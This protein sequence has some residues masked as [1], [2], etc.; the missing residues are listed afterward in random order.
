MVTGLSW[1]VPL[2]PHQGCAST[3]SCRYGGSLYMGSR[4]G[5]TWPLP[6]S[7]KPNPSV[8][9]IQAA[10]HVDMPF[11][12]FDQ[13]TMH[14]EAVNGQLPDIDMVT[15][16]AFEL[17]IIIMSVSIWSSSNKGFLA[18]LNFSKLPGSVGTYSVHSGRHTPP[19]PQQASWHCRLC[20]KSTGPAR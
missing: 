18:F 9:A 5:M 6:H 11:S 14:V 15:P 1:C 10:I 13:L 7:S 8:G 12:H 20:G 17:L 3:Y 4:Y 19:T 16:Q 2:T